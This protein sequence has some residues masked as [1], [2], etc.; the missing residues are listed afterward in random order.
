L[1]IQTILVQQ[2]L[3]DFD[4]KNGD[5]DDLDNICSSD[6]GPTKQKLHRFKLIDEITFVKGQVF[7]SAELIRTSVREFA[8]QVRKNIYIK[9]NESK[10][11]VAKCVDTF[12]FYMRF[13]KAPP[14]I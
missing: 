9:K 2:R 10:R 13:S 6:N 14:K 8:L 12:P 7:T 1:K 11:I 4:D 5:S 3:E